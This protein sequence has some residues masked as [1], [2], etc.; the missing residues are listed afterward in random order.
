MSQ[1]QPFSPTAGAPSTPS[2]MNSNL[3]GTPSKM[4]EDNI[5]ELKEMIP[6]SVPAENDIMQLSRLGDITAIKDLFETG[7]YDANYKDG[8]GITPLHWAAIN[9]QYALCKYLIECGADV[10]AK[11]GESV[12]TP[13]MWAAQKCNY[14]VV[15]LL[16]LNKAD[17]LLADIQGY[18]ILHLATFEGNLFLLVLLLHQNIPVDIPDPHGHTSLMWA[19]YKGLP[20]CVD[21]FLRWGADVH[22]TDEGGFT[23][24]HWA[25]VKGSQGC[26]QKLIE[27]GSDR[28]AE[29]SSGK[30]PAVTAE[31]MKSTYIWHRALDECGYDEDG[32]SRTSSFPLSPLI[33]DKKTFLT[34]FFFLWPFLIILTVITIF[35]KVAI[36]LGFPIAL[37]SG[38]FLY[39][40]ATQALRWAP[41][42]MRQLYRTPWLAGI[43]A[44]SCF[45][46]GFRWITVIL[47]KTFFTN[48]FLNISFAT[49]YGLCCYFYVC[50]MIYDPGFVPKLGGLSKQKAAIEELLSLWKFD[51]NYFCVQCMNRSPLR[52][53]HCK[54]CGRCVSKQ[55][56]HCPWVHNCVGV[57]NHRHFFAYIICLEIGVIIFDHLVLA[58]LDHLPLPSYTKCNV[59]SEA[60]CGMILKDNFTV[61]IAFWATL[62]LT[63]VSMLITVQLIQV[64]RGQT[65]YENMTGLEYENKTTEA[66]TA[67]LVAGTTTL[68]GAQLPGSGINRN[69]DG[70]KHHPHHKEGFFKQ[71]KKLLGLD[72]FV[73][74]AQDGLDTSGS[75]R[76]K[77]RNP[78]SRGVLVN[79]QDFWCDPAPLFGQRETGTAMLGG[80][81]VDYSRMYEPPPRMR[82]RARAAG[83]G[84]EYQSVDADDNV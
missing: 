18:N 81:V 55:D 33:T 10:N 4:S 62:Q 47:P 13:A 26:I 17:P 64:G 3:T 49:F 21:L 58:Y 54:R 30:T 2:I 9:N 35:S 83:A 46:V 41:N 59:L 61:I 56:H 6:P 65:T 28:F 37:I 82:A 29:T 31:E 48:P 73:A 23:A 8:E 68:D 71:W 72:A 66:L 77:N 36:F 74:T 12:A 27:Y 43:F 78:F 24:L 69:S 76:R 52:S 63:W 45:W 75:R 42:D 14:Y 1:D 51:E 19:A 50:S 11:G 20:A 32:N 80:T 84:G 57:N 70:H 7:K 16:L 5:V 22:A 25:L 60:L 67:A 39:W 38:Y 40:V 53:K 44:G 34:K 79:C 15:S